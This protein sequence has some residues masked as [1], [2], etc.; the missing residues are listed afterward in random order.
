MKSARDAYLRAVVS[1]VD[2]VKAVARGVA[3]VPGQVAGLAAGSL[4][5]LYTPEMQNIITSKYPAIAEM[6]NSASSLGEH[7]RQDYGGWENVKRTAAEKPFQFAGDAAAFAAPAAGLARRGAANAFASGI[8][9]PSPKMRRG[10][11]LL[12]GN[13]HRINELR[14]RLTAPHPLEEFDVDATSVRQ[15]P[16]VFTKHHGLLRKNNIDIGGGKFDDATEFLSNVGVN[17]RVIDPYSRTHDHNRQVFDELTRVPPDSATIA[18]VLN[19]I[20][21]PRIR[22]QVLEDARDL[23]MPDSPI[24]IGI[25]EGN[26]KG[27]AGPAK[28]G[29]KTT[30]QNN[31]KTESYMNEVRE[32]FPNA[33]RKGKA[34]IAYSPKNLHGEIREGLD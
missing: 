2:P 11:I 20:S 5:H 27:V 8:H 10:S 29:K 1:G 18:N 33:V 17:S 32:V 19:V 4:A 28:K 25:Y 21:D 22:R 9:F 15:I 6:M 34:I 26:G 13:T 7:Y 30:W 23:T 31:M 3:S 16:G 14:G 24:L 12:S